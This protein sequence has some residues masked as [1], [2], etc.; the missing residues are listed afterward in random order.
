MRT[1]SS[2]YNNQVENCPDTNGGYITPHGMSH[3]FQRMN[4]IVSKLIP[5]TLHPLEVQEYTMT[6]QGGAEPLPVIPVS[7]LKGQLRDRIQADKSCMTVCINKTKLNHLQSVIT[8][9]RKKMKESYTNTEF[10]ITLRHP[11]F[12][13]NRVLRSIEVELFQITPSH[14]IM[15]F[16]SHSI[17]PSFRDG[18]WVLKV[19]AHQIA[20]T[21]SECYSIHKR[22]DRMGVNVLNFDKLKRSLQVKI[23]DGFFHFSFSGE[24]FCVAEQAFNKHLKVYLNDPEKIS[25]FSDMLWQLPPPQATVTPSKK[26]DPSAATQSKF[27]KLNQRKPRIK[28]QP[29]I[30]SHPFTQAAVFQYMANPQAL[31]GPHFTGT[32]PS[33][34]A[35]AFP[36]QQVARNFQSVAPQFA[37]SPSSSSS[38][39]SPPQPIIPAP[40]YVEPVQSPMIEEQ[41]P[42]CGKRQ[43]VPEAESVIEEPSCKKLRIDA[44]HDK[45]L[46]SQDWECFMNECWASLADDL[47]ARL[48]SSLL[49]CEFES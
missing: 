23:D 6:F 18:C 49:K 39:S 32:H 26:Q 43:R 10:T 29:I 13:P 30:K 33:Y 41:I 20:L 1:H 21:Q 45:S 42:M 46:D 34:Q 27:F 35:N 47:A 11:K 12:A 48:D 37:F 15:A 31:M 38:S 25:A 2:N 4:P 44:S 28:P 17:V 3:E 36:F 24:V 14:R 8:G 7:L 9:T 22:S 5:Q 16:S 19:K 40:V